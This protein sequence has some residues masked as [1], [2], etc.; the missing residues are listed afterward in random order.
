MIRDQNVRTKYR[1]QNNTQNKRETKEK[2]F[3][4]CLWFRVRCEKHH[5]HGADSE[6]TEYFI[7]LLTCS[8][9]TKIRGLCAC[10]VHCF[11]LLSFSDPFAKLASKHWVVWLANILFECCYANW[12]L[13]FSFLLWV[14]LHMMMNDRSK[15]IANC[16]GN[17]ILSKPPGNEHNNGEKKEKSNIQYLT[18]DNL[19]FNPDKERKRENKSWQNYAN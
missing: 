18:T 15:N 8:W 4:F 19:D 2:T 1:S 6:K 3:V 5:D 10:H 13:I 11:S 14:G 9:H 17:N 16:N 12:P 7:W